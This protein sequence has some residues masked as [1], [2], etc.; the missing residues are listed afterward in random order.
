VKPKAGEAALTRATAELH[1]RREAVLSPEVS[2]RIARTLVDIGDRVR[3]GQA[4]LELSSSTPALQVEQAKA[5]KAGP[6]SASRPPRSSTPA[7]WS[8][9]RA[10]PRRRRSS[11]A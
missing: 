1:A 10:T 8:S 6:R 4:L 3:K 11:I 7:R 5:A 2:G 9:R